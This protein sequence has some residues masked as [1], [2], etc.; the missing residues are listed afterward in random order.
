V[1]Q[2]LLCIAES[3]VAMQETKSTC[4]YCGVGRDVIIAHDGGRISGVRGDPEN[5]RARP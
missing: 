4:C 5:R 1:A 3:E 2:A